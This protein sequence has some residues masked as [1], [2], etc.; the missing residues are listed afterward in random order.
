MSEQDKKDLLLEMKG[1]EELKSQTDDF[2]EQLKIADKIHNI[3][4]KLNGTKPM[5]SYI[6]CE[7]CGS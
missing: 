5:D 1:L 2:E 4:M 3:K 6:E 7:G